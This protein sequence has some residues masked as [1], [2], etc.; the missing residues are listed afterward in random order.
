MEISD[1]VD[2][3]S[4]TVILYA[5]AVVCLYALLGFVNSH[6][7]IRGSDQFW[8]VADT[9]S[10]LNGEGVQ[11][12]YI[13][14][15]NVENDTTI[16]NQ[17]FVHNVP[18]IYLAAIPG[19]V[20]GAYNGWLFMNA[21]FNLLTAVL[22]FLTLTRF[23]PEDISILAALLYLVMPLAF[24]H[25]YQPLAEAFHALLMTSILYIYY[26]GS[27]NSSRYFAIG[28]VIVVL[29]L[30][31]K[32]YI[33]VAPFVS[34]LLFFELKQRYR[35]ALSFFFLGGIL[36]LSASLKLFFPDTYDY[37]YTY[38][39]VTGN[40]AS[41]DSTTI[42][43]LVNIYANKFFEFFKVQFL[44]LNSSAIF[45]LPFDLLA[46]G[47]LYVWLR[48]A[49]RRLDAPVLL[50]A[51]GLLFL[52]LT[53]VVAWYQARYQLPFY[54]LLIFAFFIE[55]KAL[56]EEASLR[57][58]LRVVLPSLILLGLATDSVLTCWTWQG[59]KTAEAVRRHYSVMY[60]EA[61]G[62]TES[63]IYT[64]QDWGIMTT[65]LLRP[66]KVFLG[67]EELYLSTR[68]YSKLI[69]AQDIRWLLTWNNLGMERQFPGHELRL[70]REFP[71]FET[72]PTR[73]LYR[74]VATKENSP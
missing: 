40:V 26:Y 10:L 15:H 50:V 14:P 4:R 1:R 29:V 42:M 39:A 43:Q 31:R 3:P 64:G 11:T 22:L 56:L 53:A 9:E 62:N 54:P 61:I 6:G 67:D 71:A 52:L 12:N 33:I 58:T 63:V 73:Y 16:R 41:V 48:Y 69:E 32:N 47:T 68:K 70:E 18:Q 17:G 49:R 25:S 8:Y 21:L 72:E 19:L 27:K 74:I 37:T 66:R 30:C 13:R 65:Y 2:K 44:P 38:V 34:A 51:A 60:N 46:L 57:R 55:A 35:F 59:G 23:L 45:Y 36:L 20:L 28:I 24:W 7:G 5:L